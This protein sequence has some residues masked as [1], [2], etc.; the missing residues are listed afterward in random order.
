MNSIK[1]SALGCLIL[2]LTACCQPTAAA[3]DRV[4]VNFDRNWRFHLGD[5]ENGQKAVIDDSS[6]RQLDVPHDW[7]IEGGDVGERRNLPILSIVE[8]KWQFHRGD[9]TEWK[10]PTIKADGWETVQL[11]N[12]W[13]DH[14]GYNDQHCFGW[15][16]RTIQIPQD[17]QGKTILLSLGKIDDSDETFLN[18]KKI[19]ATGQ[20]PP[21]YSTA[22]ETSRLYK[23][24]A[25][26]VRAGENVVAVRVYNG[27]GKGGMYEAGTTTIQTEGPFDPLSP[28]GDGGGYLNGG[29][30]WYRK[31]FATPPEAK[32]RRVSIEFDG[33]YMDSDVWLNGKHLG[34]HPYGFTSFS[35]DLTNALK[36][37]GQ[38]VLAV[39]VNVAQPCCRWY[40][41]AGIFRHVRLQMLDPVHVAHWG[42]YVTTPTV[43]PDSAD[44]KISTRVENQGAAAVELQLWTEIIGPDGKVLR[45]SAE[46]PNR[47]VAAGGETTFVQ[48]VSVGQ[49]KLWSPESPQL[50]CATSHVI[51]AGETADFV[52]TNFGIRTVEFTKDRGMLINGRRVPVNGVCNHHDLG[53][54]GTAV[55][56]RGIQRQLEILKGMGCNA[57][58][59]SHNPPD[60]DLLSLCDAM[61]FVVMD[62][63]FDE[64]KA[65]KTPL[66]YGRFFDE[67]SERDLVSML[68]RDR[69]HP[70]IV[71]WSIGNEIPEQGARN[72]YEMS[73]RLVDICHRED[74][75]RLTV[76]A[77]NDPGGANRTGFARPLGVFG[78]NY[79]IFA[80]RQFK[81]R[82]N[83]IGSETS[84]ALSTRDEYGLKVGKDG[85]VQIQREF[86]HQVTSYDLVAPGWGYIAETDLLAL[87]H[88]PWVAGEFVWTGFDYIGEPTPYRW[89][90]RSSYFGIVDLAGFPK[91][92]YYFYRSVWRPEPLVH[93]LPHWTWPGLEDK[94]IPVWAVTNCDAVELFLNGKSLGEK[95]LD[96]EKSLHVAWSVPY[97]A[98]TLRAVAKKDGKEIATDEVR[99]AGKPKRILLRPDRERFLADGEDLSF[100]E[101]RA[102]DDQGIVCPGASNLVRFYLSGPAT[103]AGVDNGDPINHEPFRA[104]KHTVFHGL[105]LVVVNSSHSSGKIT[106]RGEADGLEGAEVSL[107]TTEPPKPVR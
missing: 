24:D 54:L 35:Y 91:D 21:H 26:L 70:C 61:G 63:A 18:G 25:K 74:P 73:K 67:W 75:T 62:E 66:G 65:S 39:R 32:N 38:N 58:R 52:T 79:N 12:W 89:P 17:M 22:W 88:S 64:W 59:T 1:A 80:Y 94:E 8:G 31:T 84:S 36:S 83:L 105:G 6:W 86:D 33:V 47:V 78:I 60:P 96:R 30:G 77:C 95:K 11:P 107:E 19:G 57:I 53:C 5:V 69:N 50:Y 55:H 28:A 51:V 45:A 81:G 46:P 101:V 93:L 106:L 37:E 48:T 68:D 85:K 40:S 4:T 49:P 14:S 16:R 103:I 102:V 71:L 92:R 23:I 29:I 104:D 9:N 100:I 98:G 42:T 82:Y 15:Y 13:N 20:M 41:G 72:G 76:S 27:E 97:A 44:V 3:G 56:R 87:Q 2:L 34:R 10:K 99:T 90:S 43:T 7:S